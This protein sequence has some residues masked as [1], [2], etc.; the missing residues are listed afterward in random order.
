MNQLF[1]PDAKL[2]TEKARETARL[3][4]QHAERTLAA[5]RAA[6]TVQESL[7]EDVKPVDASG[8]VSLW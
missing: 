8:Q 6:G 4:R 7:Y 1:K 2:E 3:T 5:K